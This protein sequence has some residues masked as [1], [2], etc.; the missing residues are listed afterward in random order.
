MK[1]LILINNDDHKEHGQVDIPKASGESNFYDIQPVMEVYNLSYT[2]PDGTPALNKVSFRVNEG[3]KIA[4]IGPNG[5][6]KSTLLLHLCGLLRGKGRIK[7][8]G[9]E[10][11]RENLK[12]I[13]SKTGFLFQNTDDQLFLPTVFDDVA[14]GLM[15]G[16]NLPQVEI[17]KRVEC[18]LE[19]M[20][21]SHLADRSILHLSPG[22]KKKVALAG[23][24][25]TEPEILLFD[26]PTAGLD[27]AGR[28][29]LI[30]E[31]KSLN[32]TMLIATHDLDFVTNVARRTMLMSRGC[33]IAEGPTPNIL[34]DEKLLLES[35]L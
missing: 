30:A 23:A 33:L 13:R 24:L 12:F 26:E 19:K 1:K 2:Y 32:K 31:L 20:K 22:E 25:V 28:R 10:L 18:I 21:I 4:I 15:A 9:H 29:W 16:K 14:F 6:G 3:E 7:I 34:S 8:L 17:K 11:N 5:A 35:G 27:P